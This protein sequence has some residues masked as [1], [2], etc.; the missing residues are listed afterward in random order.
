MSD[1]LRLGLASGPI[2]KPRDF[3]SGAV[4]LGLGIFAALN[5]VDYG[6]GT[7]RKMGPGYFPLALGVILAAIGLALVVR[8]LVGQREQPLPEFKWAPLT[9][10]TGAVI[11]FGLIVR[12]AGLVPAVL[13]I[14]VASA[15]ASRRFG[16]L[17]ALL[18]GLGASLFSWALFVLALGLPFAAFGP[19]LHF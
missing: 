13:L 7:A 6:L 3:W 5:A 8:S 10:V 1:A 12:G 9:I 15:G 14:A 17:P 2:R 4:F 18:I 11:I 19:W 16:L